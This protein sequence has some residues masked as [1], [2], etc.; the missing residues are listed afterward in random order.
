MKRTCIPKAAEA[1]RYAVDNEAR[2]INWSGFVNT[3]DLEKLKSLKEAID[4]AELKGVLLVVAAD[5]IVHFPTE[6]EGRETYARL[7]EIAGI[8]KSI[9]AEKRPI[10]L[11]DIQEKCR[12]VLDT[13][14]KASQ[15]SI[16]AMGQILL[17]KK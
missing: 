1:I 5:Y 14:K 3:K 10:D 2:V 13:Y 12:F 15:L 7:N 9:L 4:Y 11:E 17:L 8:F 6:E 16:M